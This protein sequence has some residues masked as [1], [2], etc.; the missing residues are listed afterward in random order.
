MK[1]ILLV[2]AA[3]L[4]LAAAAGAVLWHMKTHEVKK[5][6]GSPTVQFTPRE[7]PGVVKRPKRVVKLTPWP[8]YGYDVARSHYG[9]PFHIRPPFRRTWVVNARYYVEFPP[10]VAD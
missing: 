2:L 1:R 9:E 7:K 4:V 6:T 3:V 8:T 10:A 5:K